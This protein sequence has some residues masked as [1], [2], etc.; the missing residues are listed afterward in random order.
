[1][2]DAFNRYLE[3]ASGISKVTKQTAEGIVKSLVEQGQLAARNPQE[4]VENLV[5]RSHENREALLTM[6]RSE[7]KRAVKRMGLATQN[8][9]ERL[10]RQV[11]DLRRRL[12]EAEAEVVDA[13]GSTSRQGDTSAPD[14]RKEAAKRTAR[15]TTKKAAK[16][17]AKERAK[18]G[19]AKRAATGTAGKKTARKKTTKKSATKK[20]QTGSGDG[21]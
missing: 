1:M 20:T 18:K 5:E 14:A 12:R 4:L 15:A 2:S 7:T 6:V 16:T 10:Q 9:V 13:Q 17:G 11:G 8:D 3:A 19:A 21:S